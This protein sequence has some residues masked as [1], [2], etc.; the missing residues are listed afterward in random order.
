MKLFSVT[1]DV[2]A[3]EVPVGVF[4]PTMVEGMRIASERALRVVMGMIISKEPTLRTPEWDVG[5]SIQSQLRSTNMD[6][7]QILRY[8]QEYIDSN[9][10]EIWKERAKK[11]RAAAEANGYSGLSE[12]VSWFNGDVD[13]II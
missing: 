9:D 10:G 11:L 1:I 13:T 7:E 5:F 6:E 12:L 3:A 4:N 2:T 8:I